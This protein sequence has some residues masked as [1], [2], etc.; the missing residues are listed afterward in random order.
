MTGW[1]RINN[2]HLN[3]QALCHRQETGHRTH[4]Q[5]RSQIQD[6]KRSEQNR[7]KIW[8]LNQLYYYCIALLTLRFR[9]LWLVRRSYRFFFFA[10]LEVLRHSR[11]KL[12]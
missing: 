4:R 8:R 10:F 11:F 9:S 6:E 5:K 7:K 1:K 2:E 3:F 12:Y